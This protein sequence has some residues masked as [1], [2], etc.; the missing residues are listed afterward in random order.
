MKNVK[1]LITEIKDS[2]VLA[3]DLAYCSIFF[4]SK[5]IASEVLKIEEKIKSMRKETEERILHVKTEDKEALTGLLR[6]ASYSE[7]IVIITAEM[8]KQ[9]IEG[10]IHEIAKKALAEAE[11]KFLKFKIE[12]EF[13]SRTVAE[14][15]DIKDVE[16]IA[17][18][19]KKFWIYKP[20][21]KVQFKKGD[22]VIGMTPRLYK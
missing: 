16:I 1:E 15:A 17:I 6:I 3:L 4:D 22:V 5:E 14:V 19:R 20:K 2:T 21:G 12:K 7:R 10:K 18:K 13:D 11:E 8:A 9:V